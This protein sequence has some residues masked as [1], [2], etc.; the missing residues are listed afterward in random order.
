MEIILLSAVPAQPLLKAGREVL[1]A[2]SDSWAKWLCASPGMAL[3]LF[4]GAELRPLNKSILGG[5]I[6]IS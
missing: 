6:L 4:M 2:G 3:Q 1:V 5:I